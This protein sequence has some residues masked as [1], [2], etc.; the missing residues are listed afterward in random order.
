MDFGGIFATYFVIPS[1]SPNATS[2][3]SAVECY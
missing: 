2:T 3:I 1:E